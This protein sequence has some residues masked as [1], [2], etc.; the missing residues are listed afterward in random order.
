MGRRCRLVTG[1]GSDADVIQ[2]RKIQMRDFRHELRAVVQ[3]A[4]LQGRFIFPVSMADLQLKLC[5]GT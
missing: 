1:A 4:A 5:A 3:G 2:G